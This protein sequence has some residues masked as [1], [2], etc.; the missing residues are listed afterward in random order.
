MKPNNFPLRP[1]LNGSEE[2]YTQTNGVSEKFSLESAKQFI[3][4]AFQATYAELQTLVSN[5]ELKTGSYYLLTDFETIYDR[6]DYQAGG[7]LPY[8]P[9]STILT[10]NSGVIEPL[11]LL[12]ISED[13]FAAE[14]HSQTYPDDYLE[15]DFGYNTTPINSS[16]AKGKIIRRRDDNYNETNYDHRTITFKRYDRS[17]DNNYIWFFDSG[18]DN[19]VLLPTFGSDCKNNYFERTLPS[20]FN[21]NFDLENN[22]FGG[23][24]EFNKFGSVIVNNTVGDFF[25][26][27]TVGNIFFENTVGNNFQNNTV[28]NFFFNNTIGNNFQYNTLG[29]GFQNNTVDIFFRNNKV[30][31][32]FGGNTIGEY[33]QQNKIGNFFNNNNISNGFA[34]NSIG[35]NFQ[36]N[37]SIGTNF[38]SNSIGNF[39]QVNTVGNDFTF[40]KIGDSFD[41]NTVGDFFKRNQIDYSPTSTDFSSATHVYGDYTCKIFKS[42]DTNFYLEYFSGTTATYD[43]PTA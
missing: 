29:N 24:C 22:V 42:N 10:V 25:I 40:N 23:N 12:A 17:G 18:S 43:S 16:P 1:S 26:Y 30:G 7:R 4:V 3:N 32:S 37:T 36:S 39:F 35:D 33:F 41:T 20:L 8:I 11:L 9:K 14:V 31:N 13:E 28:S 21:Y 6:P 19:S 27:N 38:L 34:E 5:Q 2:L 15:Y